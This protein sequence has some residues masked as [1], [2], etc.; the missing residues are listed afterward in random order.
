M[1]GSRLLVQTPSRLHFGLLGWGRHGG[2]QFGGLG[3]MIREPA[4]RLTAESAQRTSVEG[5]L[6]SRVE[7]I[8]GLLRKELP[9]RGMVVDPVSIRIL[10]AP[11][12]HVGLGVGT[13]LTL[14]VAEAVIRLAGLAPPAAEALAGLT[15]RGRRSG[16]GLHGYR[17]GGFL[18][19]GGRKDENGLPPLLVRL[20]FPADWSVVVVQPPG[21]PGLH[22]REELQAF[23]DLPPIS[24]RVTE[25]L[26][27]IVLLEIL[28]AIVERDLSGF[29]AGLEELQARV[30]ECFAPAQGGSFRSGLADDIIGELHR[31]GFVG[32][33][34]SSW[35]PTLYGFTDAPAAEAAGLAD[36]LRERLGLSSRSVLVSRAANRG[37]TFE[38]LE[39]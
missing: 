8:L 36:A 6:A 13:Q 32:C 27:R 10:D 20:E 16:V 12:E 22:G 33:G 37:S 29:G 23:A 26:C 30:G 9:R 28:P 39:H 21:S 17:Q 38:L 3:L 14:S 25:R 2:R 19:D 18:V 34:Q 15:G 35:G 4:I 7:R 24:D 1:T 11:P 31:S 5:P